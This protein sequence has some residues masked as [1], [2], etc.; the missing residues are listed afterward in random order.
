MCIE[1]YR[2]GTDPKISLPEKERWKRQSE[3]VVSELNFRRKRAE[4]RQKEKIEQSDSPNSQSPVAP[5]VEIAD[6]RCKEIIT[7]KGG[8][9]TKWVRGL[10]IRIEQLRQHQ[11]NSVALREIIH[12]QHTLRQ[13]REMQFLRGGASM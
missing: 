2:Q 1:R 12:T 5:G 8:L 7:H 10:S 4:E 11:K 13:S 6:V 3:M 9:K